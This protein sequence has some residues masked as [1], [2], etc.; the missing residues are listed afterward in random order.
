M[1]FDSDNDVGISIVL[2]LGIY[3]LLCWIVVVVIVQ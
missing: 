1:V 2:D 3:G